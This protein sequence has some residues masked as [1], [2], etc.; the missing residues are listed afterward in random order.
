[1]FSNKN[2]IELCISCD[3]FHFCQLAFPQFFSEHNPSCILTCMNL[4]YFP[5][6]CVLLF[7]CS[8][9]LQLIISQI[10]SQ[11]PFVNQPLLSLPD[12]DCFSPSSA[13]CIS[14]LWKH[15][16]FFSITEDILRGSLSPLDR[17]QALYRAAYP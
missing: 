15:K 3:Q 17:D 4:R 14:A 9:Y 11:S 12:N 7:S 16:L 13:F 8:K 5:F 2:V 1:M 10:P 6:S